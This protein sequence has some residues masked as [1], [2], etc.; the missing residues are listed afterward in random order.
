MD[1][2]IRRRNARS[3]P[4][5]VVVTLVSVGSLSLGMPASSAVVSTC[6]ARN[7]TQDSAAD[8]NLQAVIQAAT[9]NDV[10]VVRFVCV[11]NFT[12]AKNLTLIGRPSADLPWGV[13]NANGHGQVLVV[14]RAKVTLKNLK[15]T[16]GDDS[17]WHFG[18]G[19]TT[20]ARLLRL[21]DTVVDGNTG[22][23]IYN[24][25]TLTLNGSSTISHN[26]E[27][28]IHQD[29]YVAPIGASL[30]MNGTSTITGNSGFGIYDYY[31]H[32]TLNDISSV[33]GNV[34]DVIDAVYNWEGT[35]TL[36][37]AA[38]VADNIGNNAAI[39]NGA[40][41]TMNGSS[42]VNGNV[43]T[44]WRG[45]G[46]YNGSTGNATMNDSST[47]TGN[48]TVRSGGGVGSDGVFTMNGSSSITGNT[49]DADDN[50]SGNG[51]GV[52]LACSA[53][54]TGGIDGGNVNDNYLGTASPVENNI[55]GPSC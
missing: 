43:T 10:I 48:S 51:G 11:G 27:A 29:G 19:I 44:V 39:W 30:T 25:G 13:L 7:V 36:N 14:P 41:L 1:R 40:S 31:A 20:S 5:I 49:A 35:F 47:V 34:T 9:K 52:W 55:G 37:E 24:T 6:R 53:T 42:S 4:S 21:K 50:G 15:I 28:G 17:R 12:I 23:G 46:I 18:A 8:S 16:G 26:S 54:L 2:P 22:T 38:S 45:G 33:S 32:A 3:V